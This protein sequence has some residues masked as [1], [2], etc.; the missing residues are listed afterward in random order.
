M[1]LPSPA[2]P[3]HLCEGTDSW[4]EGR[5]SEQTYTFTQYY[6]K[7]SVVS[8]NL[9]KPL[10][11]S[12][13]LHHSAC[14]FLSLLPGHYPFLVPDTSL[15]QP[16][17]VFPLNPYVHPVVP[18]H[19]RFARPYL[20][21]WHKRSWPLDKVLLFFFSHPWCR[22]S[23][24]AL[25]WL[26]PASALA[27]RPRGPNRSHQLCISPTAPWCQLCKADKSSGHESHRNK[28]FTVSADRM[29]RGLWEG[30]QESR[31]KKYASLTQRTSVT[32][33]E[34]D[35][36]RWTCISNRTGYGWGTLTH[37]KQGYQDFM[38]DCVILEKVE[39]NPL[40]TQLKCQII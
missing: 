33:S 2:S 36:L 22:S 9:P 38:I 18:F 16:T 24:R 31:E 32:S 14:F 34:L 37:R 7:S 13:P 25:A 11:L 10:K 20:C 3:C 35:V 29:S 6:Q 8:P 5:R 1:S 19:S 17:L 4:E 40:N 28:E 30:K 27:G 39:F 23:A 12:S 15:P 21:T 26:L